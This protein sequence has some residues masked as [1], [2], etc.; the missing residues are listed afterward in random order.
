MELKKEKAISL[1]TS[2]ELQI[3]ISDRIPSTNSL[4]NLHSTE[5]P[6]RLLYNYIYS[7]MSYFQSNSLELKI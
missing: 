5:K 3:D 7:R 1:R 6:F 4:T 2:T